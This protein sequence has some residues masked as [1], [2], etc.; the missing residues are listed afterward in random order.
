[1]ECSVHGQHERAESAVTRRRP[2]AGLAR[3][4][5]TPA[6]SSAPVLVPGGRLGNGVAA[7][8]YI[9][10]VWLLA[11]G[12][13]GGRGAAREVAA[14]RPQAG[15]CGGGRA[16]KLAIMPAGP[17]A[18]TQ[19]HRLPR[20]GQLVPDR[21]DSLTRAWLAGRAAGGRTGA[22]PAGP[23]PGWPGAACR[24]L[25]RD[26]R[27]AAGPR[28]ATRARTG[29]TLGFRSR[30]SGRVRP[31]SAARRDA[32]RRCG[33]PPTPGKTADRSPSAGTRACG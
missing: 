15:R 17:G 6:L 18:Q 24:R 7:A 19:A 25:G 3:R 22:R 1:M 12:V 11:C 14:W 8:L 32:G 9:A 33:P 28:P 27:P 21:G 5:I 29:A 26:R 2:G 4:R 16:A 20:F 23:P 31:G 13:A 10:S 30:P